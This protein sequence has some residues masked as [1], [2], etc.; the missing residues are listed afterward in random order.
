MLK[1]DKEGGHL[2]W[3]IRR[4][5]RFRSHSLCWAITTDAHNLH[6]AASMVSLFFFCPLCS[7]YVRKLRDCNVKQSGIYVQKLDTYFTMA[8]ATARA[9]FFFFFEGRILKCIHFYIT[10]YCI[11]SHKTSRV[12]DRARGRF[13]RAKA[14]RTSVQ[15]VSKLLVLRLNVEWKTVAFTNPVKPTGLPFPLLQKCYFYTNVYGW[16]NGTVQ[17]LASNVL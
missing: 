13:D 5:L 12:Y 3:R 17:I 14:K 4:R 1:Y 7:C 16:K 6:H 9:F 11:W 2:E 8:P 15:L 10:L